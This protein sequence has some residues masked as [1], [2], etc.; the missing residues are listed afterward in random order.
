MRVRVASILPVLVR[1]L[2]VLLV[3]LLLVVGVAEGDGPKG[4]LDADP[5]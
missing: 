3:L 2:P 4:G 5:A 1:L